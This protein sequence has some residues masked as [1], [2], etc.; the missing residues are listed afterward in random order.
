[1]FIYSFSIYLLYQNYLKCK[2]TKT[3]KNFPCSLIIIY[4]C[5]GKE[6]SGRIEL[7]VIDK[8]VELPLKY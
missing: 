6:G 8:T 3:L 4:E 5:D 2:Q 1:M 7:G